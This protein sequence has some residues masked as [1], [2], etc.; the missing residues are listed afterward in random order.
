MDSSNNLKDSTM[1]STMESSENV[2]D[3]GN[4]WWKT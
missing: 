2:K 3:Y 1:E 4:N